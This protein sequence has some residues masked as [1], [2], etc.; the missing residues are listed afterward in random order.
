[1]PIQLAK[2]AVSSKPRFNWPPGMASEDLYRCATL[3]SDGRT[4]TESQLRSATPRPCPPTLLAAE[5]LEKLTPPVI[6]PSTG[7][8]VDLERRR[9]V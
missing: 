1:M 9:T 2:C 3:I 8:A 7:V 4:A 5:G 6:Q